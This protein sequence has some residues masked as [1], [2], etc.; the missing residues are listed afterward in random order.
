LCITYLK[1][2]KPEIFQ[3]WDFFFRLQNICIDV[4][5]YN[6]TEPKSKYKFT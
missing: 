6:G 1:C 2:L 4:I 5:K 3:I